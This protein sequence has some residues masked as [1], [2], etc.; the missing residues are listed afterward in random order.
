MK[1]IVTTRNVTKKYSNKFAVHGVNMTIKEGDIYGLVGRNGAGKTTLMKMITSLIDETSGEIEL[2]G[3]TTKNERIKEHSRIGAIIET[4]AFFPK[5]TAKDNLE[6]YRIQKGVVESNAV[7]NVLNIVGLTEVENKKFKDFSL[8][9]KQ[10]LGLALAILGSP[11][12]LIL[13][14]PINGLDPMGIKEI[15]DI[16]T[17]LNKV[18]KT[19]IL[20]SSHILGELSQLATCYGFINN[21]ELIEELSGEELD[22]KCR[23]HIAIKVDDVETSAVLLE[24]MGCTSYDVLDEHNIRVYEY[25]NE[26]YKVNEALVKGNIKVYSLQ[27]VGSNLEDYFIQLVGGNINV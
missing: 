20:I 14:E 24:K 27:T 18:K 11:D 3:K 1:N 6:Y 23:H 9:M 15:R 17:K 21:G 4:P 7:D 22:S 12:F 26:S 8:G 16:L 19:T 5:M 10:R 25:I 2:F 13:D